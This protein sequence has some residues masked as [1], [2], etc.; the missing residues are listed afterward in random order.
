RCLLSN[1]TTPSAMIEWLVSAICGRLDVAIQ[2]PLSGP[3]R[4]PRVV[5]IE[6]S[7]N[8]GIQTSCDCISA[9]RPLLA[10]YCIQL[11]VAP[12]AQLHHSPPVRDDAQLAGGCR[13]RRL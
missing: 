11:R 12:W 7:F 13:A 6:G 8:S 10:R 9:V 2:W 3:K 1:L 5:A 4:S